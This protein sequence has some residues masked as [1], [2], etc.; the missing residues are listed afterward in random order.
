MN[1]YVRWFR[2]I[3][4]SDVP[5]VGGKNASLGERVRELAPRG[6]KVP[7][8]FAVTADA[9]RDFLR[10]THLGEEIRARLAALRPHDVEQFRQCGHHVRDAIVAARF[11]REL[12]VAC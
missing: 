4:L 5:L 1:A 3:T 12:E 11:S 2:D 8:G 10:E 9:Y 6:V 7:D